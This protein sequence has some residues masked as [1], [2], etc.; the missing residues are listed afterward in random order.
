VAL[1]NPFG[2]H[3]TT[4]LGKLTAA[5][6]DTATMN[7]A[8]APPFVLVGAITT[9]AAE[10]I[11]AWASTVPVTIAVPPP[12]D[13]DALAALE[14]L[15]TAVYGALGFAPARPASYTSGAATTSLPA[16]QLTYPAS[17]PNPDC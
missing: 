3:R 11:G 6:I 7:P 16:Y 8:A 2:D 1:V 4:M 14:E 17:I 9:S 15:L 5:G 12:G 13:L 10:G